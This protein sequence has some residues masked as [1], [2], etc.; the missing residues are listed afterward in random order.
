GSAPAAGASPGRPAVSQ[1]PRLYAGRPDHPLSGRVRAGRARL[2]IAA[3]RSGHHGQHG[4]GAV[5]AAA[6]RR[7]A[8]PAGA[9]LCGEP[10]RRDRRA[11]GRSALAARRAAAGTTDTRRCPQ[12]GALAPDPARHQEP[13]AMTRLRLFLLL[14]LGLAGCATV[15]VEAPAPQGEGTPAQHA[16]ALAALRSWRMSGR[17]AVSTARDAGT[18]SMSWQQQGER[19]GVELRA[20]WGAGTVQVDG[21]P[22]GVLLRTSQGVQEFASEPRELLE[23]Y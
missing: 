23:Y 11:S 7:G 17:A 19:Y 3:G 4:L 13:S 6:P 14:L 5:Q 1:R 8:R 2:R 12:A 10:G 15:P 20:P 22:Q 18:V 9:G 21:G 16:E